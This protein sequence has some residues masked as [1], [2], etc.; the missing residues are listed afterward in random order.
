MLVDVTE[1]ELEY[2]V[3]KCIEEGIVTGC[4]DH[5]N[6]AVY[7]GMKMPVPKI[8]PGQSPNHAMQSNAQV[9][10]AFAS[11]L[12]D[13]TISFKKTVT[14]YHDRITYC[15]QIH[16]GAVQAMKY[17]VET[18]PLKDLELAR[19]QERE[20]IKEIEEGDLDDDMDF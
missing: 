12:F 4:V 1:H 15:H 2:M 8:E 7:S 18:Q 19:E 3:G 9:S 16:N 10:S 5:T 11:S 6:G 17:K 14:Q 20:L 13:P